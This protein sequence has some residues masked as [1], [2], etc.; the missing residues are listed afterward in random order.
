MWSTDERA[1]EEKW[2]NIY[3]AGYGGFGLGQ[4]KVSFKSISKEKKNSFFL[5]FMIKTLN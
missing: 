1:S 2:R 5:I 4:G 3:L